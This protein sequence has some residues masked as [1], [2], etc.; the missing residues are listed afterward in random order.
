MLALIVS[1]SKNP[2]EPEEL[3]GVISGIITDS[4]MNEALAGATVSTSPTTSSKNTDGNGSYTIPDVAPGNY[5]VTASKEGYT[6]Q[7]VSIS[8]E[9]GRKT[10]ADIGLTSLNPTLEVSVSNLNFGTRSTSLSFTI[11]NGTGYGILEWMVETNVAWLSI[12]PAS[13]TTTTELDP[14][15]ATVDRTGLG[16]GNYTAQLHITSNWGEMYID[17]LMS[18]QNP[19]SPQLTVDK[20]NLDFGEFDTAKLFAITNTGVGELTWS[21]SEGYGWLEVTPTNGVTTTESDEVIVLVNRTDLS[22]G[23]YEGLIGLTSNG[24][25]VG[26]AV[27]MAVTETSVEPV[28]LAD[29]TDITTNSMKLAWTRSLDPDFAF[30]RLYRSSQPGVSDAST[31]IYETSTINENYFTDTGLTPATAYYYRVYTVNSDR[32][33]APSNEVH[34]TTRS[35]LGTWSVIYSSVPDQYFTD[36]HLLSESS[37]YFAGYFSTD[38]SSSAKVFYWNGSQMTIE[39]VPHSPVGSQSQISFTAISFTPSNEGWLTAFNKTWS[40]GAIAQFDGTFWNWVDEFTQ[41]RGRGSY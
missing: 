7:S 34:G 31:L 13:G 12:N 3:L 22:T 10:T 11:S 28:E 24:G 32:A 25:N 40:Y 2:S 6:S 37:G 20:Q 16:Y 41:A 5:V 30:Y 39:S 33:S 14:I 35:R 4:E 27:Q 23:V 21:I 38:G 1:C 9:A 15:T 8:V 36:F 26:I 19:S 18:V 29:P 17:V